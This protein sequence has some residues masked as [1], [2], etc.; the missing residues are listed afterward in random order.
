MLFMIS[1]AALAIVIDLN[2]YDLATALALS[3]G[4]LSNAGPA[5]YH[6]TI[7]AISIGSL[8]VVTKSGIILGMLA[9]RLELLALLGLFS[10][11]FWGR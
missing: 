6:V 10:P 2:G 1:V 7:E 4:A 5:A 11:S 9:G 3:V 8:D